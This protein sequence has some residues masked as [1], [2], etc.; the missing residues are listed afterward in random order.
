MTTS[1]VAQDPAGRR[2]LIDATVA[3]IEDEGLAGVSLRGIARRAAVSHA[4]PAH[5][6]QDKAGLFTAVA[7]EGFGLLERAMSDALATA[8]GQE[9]ERRM[10]ALGVAYVT[11]AIEHRA[12]FEVMF[13]LE[14]LHPD[15]PDL[16]AASLASFLILRNAAQA[17]KDLGFAPDW[18]V[19]DLTISA[20]ALVHGIAQLATHG[21]LS[22]VGYP[23]DAVELA[24]SLTQ[25]VSDTLARVGS[26]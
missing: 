25:L 23:V 20:W 8:D 12:H 22:Q 24:A 3:A 2:A 14:L 21:A 4:A 10:Q 16:R 1:E 6:F 15:D 26:G 13:R 7:L 17:G 18:D 5:H 19:D 9:P 11:F